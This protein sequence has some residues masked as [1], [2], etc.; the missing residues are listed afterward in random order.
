MVLVPLLAV[1]GPLALWPYFRTPEPEPVL[2]LHAA[3]EVPLDEETPAFGDQ[4]RSAL[5]EGRYSD[6]DAMAQSFR[7]RDAMFRSANPKLES[8]YTS[9]VED[10]Y[11]AD[12]FE[13][14]CR[15]PIPSSFEDT[16]ALIGR[17]QKAEPHSIT[18][19]TAYAILW[20]NYAW[21][22]R[23]CTWPSEVSDESWQ[24]VYARLAEAERLLIDV[25]PI[26]DPAAAYEM[27]QIGALRGFDR[28]QFD[29]LYFRAIAA[30]PWYYPLY[31][32]RARFLLEKWY[33]EPGD[34][35]AF[36]DDLRRKER[37]DDGQ[38]AYSVAAYR[39]TRNLDWTQLYHGTGLDKRAVF[40]AYQVRERRYGLTNSDWNALFLLALYSSYCEPAHQAFLQIGDRWDPSVWTE[41][42]YFDDSVTWF[43]AHSPY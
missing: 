35:K 2:V 22:A 16:S 23:G 11:L 38:I 3:P 13:N 12:R 29:D 19:L 14:G 43:H 40:A 8:F 24:L 36:L 41:K 6:L 10:Q 25:D 26:A 32:T 17:W 33:G 20:G 31:G 34:E 30:F 18:M 5:K 1:A 37:G 21:H 9:L 7:S 39:L 42:K 28:A 4:V 27:I 15:T